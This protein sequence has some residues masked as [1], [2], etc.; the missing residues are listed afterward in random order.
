MGATVTDVDEFTGEIDKAIDN[1]F[2]PHRITIQK[3]QDSDKELISFE[4]AAREFQAE[5]NDHPT[6]FSK[7]GSTLFEQLEMAILTLEWE[8]TPVNVSRVQELLGI[9][10]AEFLLER[11]SKLLVD[12]MEQV[13]H[14]MANS[15]GKAPVSGPNA[16]G[17]ALKL[18]KGFLDTSV[19]SS[20]PSP[21][22]VLE[23][24]KR[25]ERALPSKIRQTDAVVHEQEYEKTTQLH[26][27]CPA[28]GNSFATKIPEGLYVALQYHVTVLKQLATLI[29]PAEKLFKKSAG[30]EKFYDILCTVRQK[31]A[32]QHN[33][34]IDAL[35]NDYCCADENQNPSIPEI[36]HYALQSH[37]AIL[38]QCVKRINPAEKAFGKASGMEKLYVVHR[39]IREQL[40]K[41]TMFLARIAKGQFRSVRREQKKSCN[42]EKRCPFQSIITAEWG[43]KTVAFVAEQVTFEG[44]VA[45][46]ARGR[47]H[48][49]AYFPLRYL[50]SWPWSKL[51]P[52]LRVELAKQQENKL[53][54]IELPV[55]NHPGPFRTTDPPDGINGILILNY[56]SS[57]AAVF[58]ESKPR[59]LTVSEQWEWE[60]S[61]ELDSIV[62]GHLHID[63]KLIP[64]ATLEKVLGNAAKQS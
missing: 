18:I 26:V 39:Q 51:H 11:D 57:Q 2:N 7:D 8:V 64:V 36:L 28:N 52:Q 23:G 27:D 60:P 17:Q 13:L 35:V 30:Y 46:W 56:K 29:M 40:E 47:R 9:C 43:G 44:N 21:Q 58:L 5:S 3:G 55:L 38:E 10:R 34:Y 59:R 48:Q 6:S 15:P 61:S 62:A 24:I 19:N 54:S 22:A 31:V 14:M 33:F 49:Q 63:G 20:K 50:K 12:H 53:G 41:Q 25:L 37:M 45:W 42:V 4:Q 16:L 32:K 1:L